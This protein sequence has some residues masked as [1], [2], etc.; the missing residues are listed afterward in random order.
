M[1]FGIHHDDPG[2]SLRHELFHENEIQDEGSEVLNH[3]NL[4]K[5]GSGQLSFGQINTCVVYQ[6]IDRRIELEKFVCHPADILYIAQIGYF[7]V[8]SDSKLIFNLMAQ[9]FRFLQVSIDAKQVGFVSSVFSGGMVADAGRG[10]GDDNQFIIE[11]LCVNSRIA[12][13]VFD[14]GPYVGPLIFFEIFKEFLV[15]FQ[16]KTFSPSPEI[17]LSS[18]PA[19]TML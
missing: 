9:G 3:K 12:P 11:I 4:L 6:H 10:S 8:A 18:M 15:F 13:I 7:E 5:P 14:H 16:H 1:A 17:V 2:F 19:L